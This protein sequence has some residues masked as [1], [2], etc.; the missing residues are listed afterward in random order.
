MTT[1]QP[2]R[3]ALTADFYDS[4]GA[5]QYSDIGLSLFDSEPQITYRA[6]PENTGPKLAL[7]NWKASTA[8]LCSPRKSRRPPW[9]IFDDLLAVGRFG[10]GYDNVDVPVLHRGRCR[11]IY[12]GGVGQSLGS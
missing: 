3:L 1:A 8:S 12:Y 10:V 7:T 4:N 11:V 9:P 2:F 6:F 5:L